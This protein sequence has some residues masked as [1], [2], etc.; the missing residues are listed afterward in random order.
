MKMP[1]VFG[2]MNKK[3]K[4]L[5]ERAEE[6]GVDPL[7]ILMLRMKDLKTVCDREISKPPSRRSNIFRESQKELCQLATELAPY[8]HGKRA[9]ITT[10]DETP[11]MTVIRAPEV[12]TDTQEWL[13]VY[14]PKR[15]DAEPQPTP[16]V[17][18]VKRSLEYAEAAG[19]DDAQKI[20]NEAAKH[21]EEEDVFTRLN[22]AFLKDY[23]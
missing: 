2:S 21:V 7:E 18:A 6:L 17:A 1:R 8:L 10:V 3:T 22:K 11:R 9:N 4:E 5:R 15:L 16:I 13:K 12:I 14:G 20:V 19:V 23:E